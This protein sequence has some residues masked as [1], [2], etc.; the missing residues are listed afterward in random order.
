MLEEGWEQSLFDPEKTDVLWQKDLATDSEALG[1]NLTFSTLWVHH[2]IEG[3][4]LFLKLCNVS[5]NV[6]S[7]WPTFQGCCKDYNKGNIISA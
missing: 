3:E 5:A 4:P 7:Y 6:Q 2:V 1:L